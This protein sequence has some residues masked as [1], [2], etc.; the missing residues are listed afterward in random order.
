[1]AF[2]FKGSSYDLKL[3][4]VG[5][6]LS[7]LSRTSPIDKTINFCFYMQSSWGFWTPRRA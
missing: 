2:N 7:P 1:M 6:I 5:Q 3:P 4:T